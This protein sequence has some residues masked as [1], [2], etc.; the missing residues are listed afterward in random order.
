MSKC[1]HP[2]RLTNSKE[3]GEKLAPKFDDDNINM[4][5]KALIERRKHIKEDDEEPEDDSLEDWL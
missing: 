4:I 5:A 3:E 1:C 2:T